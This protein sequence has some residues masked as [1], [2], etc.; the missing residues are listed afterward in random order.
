LLLRGFPQAVLFKRTVAVGKSNDDVVE[1]LDSDDPSSLGEPC[2]E[3]SVLRGWL[4]VP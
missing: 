3:R 1:K 2:G 4:D